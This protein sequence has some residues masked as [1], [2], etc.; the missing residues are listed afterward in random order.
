MK[1]GLKVKFLVLCASTVILGLLSSCGGGGGD[2]GG[3]GITTVN[4]STVITPATKVLDVG[5]TANIATIPPDQSTVSFKSGT[6]SQ[7]DN[8]KSG[9]V[10]VLGV[11]PNT[12]EG[13]LK[14]VTGVQKNSDGTTTVQTGAA[15]LE[16]AVQQASVSYS[17]TF[18]NSDVVS[19]TTVAKGVS[20]AVPLAIDAGTISL[21]L[22][23]VVIYDRD[24]NLQTTGDQVTLNG[25]V[26]FKPTV[27][28][29]IE[30]DA[31][32][33]KKFTFSV[34]GEEF[35]DVTIKSAVPI[36]ALNE[37]VLLKSINL[38]TQ[39]FLIGYVPVVIS[40]ELGIYAGVKGNVSVGLSANA[41]QKLT[42]TGGVKYEN[43]SWSPINT[44]T[45]EFGAL[46]PSIDIEADAKCY[47]GPELSTKLYGVAGPYINIYGYLLL[48]ASPLR[49]PWWELFA[50]F[51]GSAGAKIEMLSGKITARYDVNLFEIKKSLAQ[52]QSPATVYYTMSGTIRSG[53]NTGPG[54]SGAS[55]SIAGKT[56]TTTSTG[57]Y[58]ITNIP[59]GTYSFS[60]SKAGYD[61]YTNAAYSVGSDLSNLSNFLTQPTAY[62]SMSG[63]IRSGSISGPV[64]S[65][66]TVSIAGMTTTTSSS[67]SYSFTGIPV[68]SYIFTV[69]K[70][71]Y[72]TFTSSAY[73]I[74]SN[75]SGLNNYLTQPVVYYAMSGTIRSGSNTGSVLSGATVSI[76]GMTTTTSSTGTYSFSSIPAGSYIFTVSKVGYDTFTSSA[77]PVG[78]NLSGISNYLT[79]TA[80]PATIT[81]PT[82]GMV[83]VKVIG[84]TY[85]M[86]DTFG[87]GGSDE[88]PTHQV[89]V[90]D[91]YIGRYEVTQGEWQAVMGSNPSYYNTCG[92]NCPVEQ[93][94]WND[95]QTYI[96]NLNQ[97]SGKSYRLPTEA[98]WEYAARSG[99]Q[100]QKY[101][102]GSDVNAVA[103]YGDSSGSTSHSVGQKQANSLGLYDMSG[104]VWEWVSDWYG[105][106]S[107]A[108]QTNP[109]GPSS[110]SDRVF[111]GGGRNNAALNMRATIRP[112]NSP[113]LRSSNL[114][115]RLVA[116]VQSAGAGTGIWQEVAL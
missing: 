114:G 106:Y 91:F 80:A 54:L 68:G 85:T 47:A 70:V 83:L 18:T 50:G 82:T 58:T 98:E 116:P 78:S 27:D 62:Y 112:Y 24:G 23:D 3:S 99:G 77:Y 89:T 28:I 113:G 69:S 34:T 46:Q 11:T 43:S 2:G 109:T 115:F 87:D 4:G 107:S 5:A 16:D 95:V 17:K 75:L 49:T 29:N 41:T 36:P 39:T 13:M 81:D 7:I 52:A 61:T 31:S 8:L 65:G 67:G 79:A 59:A 25:K 33:L 64:L 74:G 30:I 37:K 86:G 10:L 60:V 6:N 102:G 22:N 88:K 76:A 38:G 14:K 51:E 48:Q 32:T 93:V 44:Y 96:T 57:T 110:G 92:S 35:S 101:S 55:V 19:E 26:S 42:Y 1:L 111:R 56:A 90:S 94:S 63:T 21:L 40:Y 73:S 84:G 108:S 71:G 9:D 66:A 97:R 72:D 100:S 104:N 15:T 53:S 45:T 103:W 20:K 105:T 12:P